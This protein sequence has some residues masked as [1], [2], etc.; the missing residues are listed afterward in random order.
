MR[1]GL[2]LKY[3]I[4][5]GVSLLIVAALIVYLKLVTTFTMYGQDYTDSFLW[6]EKALQF[7][8][9]YAKDPL[10]PLPKVDFYTSVLD[11]NALPESIRLLLQ[12]PPTRRVGTIQIFENSATL[13][14]PLYLL[15]H[16]LADGKALYLF[17]TPGN[18]NQAESRILAEEYFKE[19]RLML[20]IIG[21][22]IPLTG[23]LLAI[24]MVWLILKRLHHLTRWSATLINPRVNVS[25]RPDFSYK[26]F[27]ILATSLAHC[28][29]RVKAAS[30]REERLLRYTSHELRTP[31]A[32]AKANLQFLALSEELSPPLQRIQRSV[33]NMQNITETLLWMSTEHSS[34][35]ARV[36]VDIRQ[37]LKDLVEEH[38]YLIDARHRTLV[39][40]VQ[41][42]TYFLPAQACRI[43]FGNLLRNALQYADEGDIE[44]TCTPQQLSMINRI[45]S[46]ESRAESADYGYGLGLELVQQLCERLGYQLH[47][48]IEA[49]HFCAVILFTSD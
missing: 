27:N 47:T 38:R 36:T 45:G 41:D 35:P 44:I 3:V 46:I 34:T 5:G 39:V 7:S 19:E 26:E 9:N 37:A 17:E 30:L 18:E 48:R 10:T 6:E 40:N 49:Q 31:L 13:P 42:G 11:K 21:L 16:P 32:I 20:V 15:V 43:I 12:S 29:Q 23:L 2:S 4:G 8:A 1:Q 33:Q 24:V 25:G 28:V 22:S 14:P